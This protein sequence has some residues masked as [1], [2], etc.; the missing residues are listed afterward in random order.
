MRPLVPWFNNDIKEV[1]K[2]RRK[3]E[4]RWWRTGLLSDLRRYKDLRNKTNNLMTEARGVFYRELIDENCGDQKRLCSVTKRLLGSG[5]E[6]QFPPFQD[7]VAL[8]NRFGEFFAQKIVTIQGKLDEMSVDVSSSKTD[9]QPEVSSIEPMTSFTLLTEHEVRK[10]IEATPKKSCPLDP[11]PTPLL[12]ACIGTLLPVITKIINLSLQN[13]IFADQWKCAL[14]HPMLKKLGLEP[15]FQNFRPVSNLQYISKLTEKAVFIQ[16]HGQMVTNNIYPELQSSY[17][18]HHSTETA[19]LKVMN[20][21]LLKMNSQHVTLLILLDLSAAFDTVDHSILLDR[22]T[23][24][25]GLQGKAHD[26]FRSYL[27]GRGNESQLMDRC[28]WNF[29]WT[30]VF[31]RVLA[32]VHCCSLF[33]PLPSLRSLNVTFLKSIATPMTPNSTS[34]SGRAMMMP[35]MSRIALWKNALRTFESG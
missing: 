7:K 23:K 8:V 32:W 29:L 12:V 22:L 26:W 28:Q 33:T 21:F 3:A 31:P 18:E 30:V 2:E 9:S 24:V 14:V 27:S 20:D 34:A 6:I 16:T 15:I 13:D 1:R 19:L 5:R 10:L 4:R 17:H 35:R 25:V 11:M